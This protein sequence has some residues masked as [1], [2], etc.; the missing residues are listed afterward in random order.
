VGQGKFRRRGATKDFSVNDS[1]RRRLLAQVNMS[2]VVEGQR[3]DF[4][5]PLRRHL[6]AHPRVKRA[7]R[8][9]EGRVGMASRPRRNMVVRLLRLSIIKA[10]RKVENKRHRKKPRRPGHNNSA[11]I[12]GAAPERTIPE[13]PF[14]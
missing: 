6:V 3:P 5:N 2:N 10:S 7:A 11:G 14:V 9:T 1:A 12:L 13:P 4:V 8:E